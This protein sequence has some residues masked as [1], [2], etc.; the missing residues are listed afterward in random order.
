MILCTPNEI[1]H[2]PIS[3]YK[4]PQNLKQPFFFFFFLGLHMWHMEV[5]GLEA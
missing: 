4:W 2:L 3:A 5:T 1:P